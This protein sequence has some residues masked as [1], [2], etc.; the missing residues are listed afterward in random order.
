MDYILRYSSKL[1]GKRIKFYREQIGMSQKELSEACGYA[2]RSSIN[3][4]EKGE[5]DI[6]KKR[7]DQIAEILKIDVMDLIGN[8]ADVA[9]EMFQSLTP[10]FQNK[11]IG[12][13]EAYLEEMRKEK[14]A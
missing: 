8:D 5:R 14:Q 9:I 12:R 13:M 1:I 6:P 2:A 3:K 11:I 10:E 4:I 7:L